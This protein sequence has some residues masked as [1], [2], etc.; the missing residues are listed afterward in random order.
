MGC[1]ITHFAVVQGVP[2]L[3]IWDTFK[4]DLIFMINAFGKDLISS[5]HHHVNRSYL[6]CGFFGEF[7]PAGEI[8]TNT[9][10]WTKSTSLKRK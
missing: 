7:L 5:H 6:G 1:Q 10:Q 9:S 4:K 3:K 8:W 2:G